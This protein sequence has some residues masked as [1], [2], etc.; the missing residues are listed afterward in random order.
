MRRTLAIFLVLVPALAAAQPPV[1]EEFQV[2]TYTTDD[3]RL[4]AVGADGA[5]GFVVS[6]VSF[7]SSG[8]DTSGDSIQAQRYAP[9]GS[10]AGAQFQ[11]N[12]WTPGTQDSPA[13]GPDGGGGFVVAWTS[14]GSGNSDTDS[15]SIQAQRYANDGSPAGGEFQVNT[16]TTSAQFDPAIGPDGAGGFVVAWESYGSGG[17]DASG[18]SVQAQRYAA[19][20]STVG[21]EFQVNTYTTSQQYFP[22]VG[23]NGVGGFVVSWESFGSSGTDSSGISVQ[24]S[25]TPPTAHRTDPSSRSTRTPSEDSWLPRSVLSASTASSSPG[26]PPQEPAPT[27]TATP[28]RRSSIPRWSSPTASSPATPRP[29]RRQCHRRQVRPVPPAAIRALTPSLLGALDVPSFQARVGAV[30]RE[31]ELEMEGVAV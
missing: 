5:G 17:T 7:G 8:T 10:P 13:V 26:R 2:N 15:W 1:G 16:Y 3:Q 30:V 12:T 6:W 9:D 27:T 28:S 11:V 4:A 19:D 14:Y 21:G 24:A 23:A 29:G 20:G 22:A 31:I 18:F 25:A